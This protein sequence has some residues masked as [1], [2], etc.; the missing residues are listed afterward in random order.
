MRRLW[1][2]G[3]LAVAIVLLTIGWIDGIVTGEQV[4]LT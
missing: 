1:A 2:L 3:A 4:D